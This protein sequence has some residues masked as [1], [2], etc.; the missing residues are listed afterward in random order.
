MLFTFH[1]TPRITLGNELYLKLLLG[2][3]N[4]KKKGISVSRIRVPKGGSVRWAGRGK[5]R[6]L[7]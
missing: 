5:G 4:T 2:V 7:S 1:N 3:C 6:V